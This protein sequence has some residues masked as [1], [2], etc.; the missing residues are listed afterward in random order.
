MTLL[1]QPMQ[2]PEYSVIAFSDDR[3]EEEISRRLTLDARADE[4]PVLTLIIGPICSGKTTIRRKKFSHG[5]VLVDAAQLF[6][7]L[8]GTDLD[9]PSSLENPM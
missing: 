3:L 9:F 8:G 2:T 4:D 1:E 7:D 5:S 6:I